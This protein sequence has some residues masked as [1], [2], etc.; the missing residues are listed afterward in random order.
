[1][2]AAMAAE[3]AVERRHCSRYA[4][5]GDELPVVLWAGPHPDQTPVHNVSRCGMALVLDHPVEPGTTLRVGLLN[6]R[7]N[8]WHLKLIRVV[9]AEPATPGQWIVGSTFLTRLSEREFRCLLHE[10]SLPPGGTAPI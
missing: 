1:M 3:E 10:P 7:D 9:H 8:F 6:R 5:R 4:P 2:T